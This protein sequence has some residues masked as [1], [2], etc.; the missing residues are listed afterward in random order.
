VRLLALGVSLLVAALAGG[1]RPQLVQ[2]GADTFAGGLGQHRSAVEPAAAARGSQIVSVYQLG[3]TFESGA[4][5][6]GVSL[7]RDRGRTWRRASIPQDPDAER[8]SDATVAWDAAHG[9][10][11]E[12]SIAVEPGQ[13]LLAFDVSRSSDG[14]AWT[15]AARAESRNAKTETVDKE[16]LA[17]D[18]TASSA[19]YGRCYL[20]YSDFASSR[21][22]TR[23]TT[24]GG[25]TWSGAVGPKMRNGLGAQPVVRPNGDLVVVYVDLPK[26]LATRSTD[27]GASFSEP[28]TIRTLQVHRAASVRNFALPSVAADGGGTIYAVWNECTFRASCTANDV[29]LSRSA[30]GI[31]WSAPARIPLGLPGERVLPTIGA[32]PATRGAAA[33]LALAFYSFRSAGCA[34]A[35]CLVDVGITTSRTAGRRWTTPLRLNRAPMRLTWLPRTISGRMLGDYFALPFAKG[36]A[37]PIVVIAGKPD[38]TLH[39]AIYA[40]SIPVG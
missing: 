17:C 25:A 1:V 6:I 11:L 35:R 26:M 7:S 38:R 9:V 21:L 13:N 18:N 37:V 29:A 19:F 39:E 32:D 31:A 4:R 30:D 24:D 34:E 8:V 3:R 20:S 22:V 15:T 10:W 5:A 40:A 23:F 33:R 14:L 12:A 27:G 2:V 16:W 36:H 28:V